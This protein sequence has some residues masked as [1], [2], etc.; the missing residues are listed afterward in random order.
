MVRF[1]LFGRR[2]LMPRLNFAFRTVQQPADII[3]V[4]QDNE[5]SG[6][7]TENSIGQ[8]VTPDKAHCGGTQRPHDGTQ[9]NV[10]GNT[11]EDHPDDKTG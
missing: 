10:A 11:D 4:F 5:Q 7:H 8:R 9:G 1:T 6:Y 3:F 2:R